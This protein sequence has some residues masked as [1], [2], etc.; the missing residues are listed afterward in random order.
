MLESLGSASTAKLPPP[1]S[2]PNY[3]AA[4]RDS[5]AFNAAIANAKS[6][7][8]SQ[9][10]PNDNLNQL[11]SGLNGDGDQF[12][13]SMQ[14]GGRVGLPLEELGIPGIGGPQTQYGY[15]VTVK[16]VGSG[17][18]AQYQVT[19]NKDLMAGANLQV[20]TPG[21]ES[22]NK[23]IFGANGVTLG[24][25][26]NLI[27]SG[28]VTMT[29]SSKQ[30]LARGL[31]AL[32]QEAQAQTLRDAGSLVDPQ[33]AIAKPTVP[34]RDIAARGQ[35][36]LGSG[37]VRSQSFPFGRRWRQDGRRP[38]ADGLGHGFRR[39]DPHPWGQRHPY[40]QLHS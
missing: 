37:L 31:G 1:P 39:S 21:G 17:P 8:P 24:V 7:R 35:S 36:L 16:Q 28:T 11:V 26:D 40:R 20:Q 15:D 13:V 22:D 38:G 32:R 29:F 25:E 19:F 10:G 9:T 3:A 12:T 30:D 18:N 6:A 27:S 34:H 23:I 14:A 33:V 4:S 2:A 5:G